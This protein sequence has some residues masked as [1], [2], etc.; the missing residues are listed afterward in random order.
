M[1]RAVPP[2]IFGTLIG[3][4]DDTDVG[5]EALDTRGLSTIGSNGFVTFTIAGTTAQG[6]GFAIALSQTQTSRSVAWSIPE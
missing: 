6:V 1:W 5:T 3:G 2:L 4:A